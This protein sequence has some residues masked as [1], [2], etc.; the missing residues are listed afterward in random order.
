MTC[1]QKS[2]HPL[3]RGKNSLKMLI[4]CNYL[5]YILLSVD[6]LF[7]LYAFHA[8]ISI[9]LVRY[10]YRSCPACSIASSDIDSDSERTTTPVAAWLR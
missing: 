4:Y 5:P 10:R 3:T 7:F 1:M 2:P 8:A 6:F 9:R